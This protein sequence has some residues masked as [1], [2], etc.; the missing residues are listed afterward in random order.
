MLYGISL[1]Q[2]T[3]KR[4]LQGPSE[5]KEPGLAQVFIWLFWS[6]IGNCCGEDWPEKHVSRK[7]DEEVDLSGSRTARRSRG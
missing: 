5:A 2:K 3:A 7:G 1:G 6:R 4:A